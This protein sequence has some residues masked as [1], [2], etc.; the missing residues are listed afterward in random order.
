MQPHDR[1]RLKKQHHQHRNQEHPMKRLPFMTKEMRDR[2]DDFQL[3]DVW[4][5]MNAHV[6]PGWHSPAAGPA[7]SPP[8][9]MDP[10]KPLV[11]MCRSG[12]SSL[13][14]CELLEKNG[15]THVTQLDGGINAWAREIDPTMPVY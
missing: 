14:A 2:N 8:L 11:V 3:L 13:D 1:K 5:T 4:K 9:G 12:S 15:F 6:R 10:A 7:R